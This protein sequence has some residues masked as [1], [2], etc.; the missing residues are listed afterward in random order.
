MAWLP[1]E[2]EGQ[3]PN[4]GAISCD[5]AREPTQRTVA[6]SRKA[7]RSPNVERPRTAQ[8]TSQAERRAMIALV[9]VFALI[10]QALFPAMA[11]ASPLAGPGMTICTEMGLKADLPADQRPAAPAHACDHCLCPAPAA[12]LPAVAG[13]PVGMVRYAAAAPALTPR[14]APVSPGRGLAAPP[15]PSRGPPTP[16]A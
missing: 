14:A 6:H 7:A 5:F 10:V 11:T 1:A 4:A 12:T 9:A 3:S 2:E 8:I 13:A 16:N 15:P